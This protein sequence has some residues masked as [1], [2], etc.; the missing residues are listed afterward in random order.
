MRNNFWHYARFFG[1]IPIGFG[2]AWMIMVGAEWAWSA[3]L[4]LLLLPLVERLSGDDVAD[5]E[6]EHPQIFVW[7]MYA[8]VVS[9]FLTFW[10]FIWSLAYAWRGIDLLGLSNLA[11][12]VLGIEMK[13][14]HTGDNWA[15]FLLYTLLMSAVSGV[16][17]VATGHEL[18]HRIHEP[19]SVFMS[20][21]GGLL[22]FFT[23]YA[24]EH[25][26]GHH[27]NVGTPV[28]SSTALRGESIY[29]YAVRTSRQDYDTAWEIEAKRLQTQGKQTWSWDNRLLR[30]YGAELLVL[31]FVL[32]ATGP[33]AIWFLF[34]VLNTHFVYKIGTYGQHY[35]I[36]RVPGSA[37][38]MHH[39]WDCANR[40]TYWV[41]DGIGRHS[42]HHLEPEKEFWNLPYYAE[43]PQYR[44]GYLTSMLICLIPPLWHRMLAPRLIE[45]DQH[46]ASPEEQNLA[47][48]ANI[49][50]GVPLLMAY[51]ARSYLLKQGADAS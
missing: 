18:S 32:I 51:G 42:H 4:L 26:Y 1:P 47:Y 45:W 40:F 21:A 22:A 50:S 37:I 46:L 23:Y 5:Y 44:Y 28:D 43:A 29:R 33:L 25:P 13:S 48:H 24:I 49:E 7:M 16:G 8:F 30:G 10:V 15:D 35:G 17:S 20:R 19:L 27:E 38:L 39:S 14:I 11:D 41:S 34:S 3:L 12:V 6:Y 2:A 31:L 36:V 9:I